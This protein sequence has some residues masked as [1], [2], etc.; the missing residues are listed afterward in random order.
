MSLD[1]NINTSQRPPSRLL[2]IWIGGFLI[3]GIIASFILFNLVR[4]LVHHWNT[5]AIAAPSAAASQPIS[6]TVK[7]NI[8][9]WTGV[10]RVSIL[11]LGIDEREQEIG[12]WRTDTM[13]VLTIDPA[14]KSAAM[15]SIPRDL[16]V[17]I[18]VYNTEGKINTAHFLGDLNNYPG[19]GPALAMATVQYN[20]GIPTQYYLRLNF[21]AFEKLIDLIGGIDV[22]VDQPINDP[23]YP[24]Y[25]GYGFDPFYL[26]AGQHHLD[27]ATALKFARE[28]HTAGGDFDRARNQRQVILAVRDKIT[29]ADMLPTLV[30][31]AGELIDTLGDSVQTDL[32]LDQLIQLAKLGTQIDS[33]NIQSLAI[34]QNMVLYLT[35]PTDPPQDVL[36]PIRDEIRKVRDKFLGIGPIVG[37]STLTETAQIRVENGTLIGGLAAKTAENLKMLGFNVLDFTSA[38]RF[39]Y[40]QSQIIDYTHKAQV[41]A[42]LAQALGLSASTIIT[43]SPGG[44]GLDVKIILGSDYKLPS[45]P[46]P[47]P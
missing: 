39:D 31:K 29:K 19:G 22:Y 16:W 24:A 18:P 6:D 26:T 41:A 37:T 13:I 28:R 27:G 25:T 2:I 44:D 14:T 38:D 17:P 7:I 43:A 10:E 3:I 8:P 4:E 36:V 33:K 45:T 9:D 30:A 32:S 20:L 40:T 35:A 46:M 5:T 42:Q 23:E 15:L 11:L 12:P 47:T 34:D 21:G 1:R